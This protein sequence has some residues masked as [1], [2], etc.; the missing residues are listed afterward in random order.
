MT[1]AL[2]FSGQG[3]QK[4]GMGQDLYETQAPYRDTI[5][6]A[7][8]VLGIDLPALYFDG[9]KADQLNETQYTQPAI[10]AMSMAVYQTIKLQLDDQVKVGLGLSLGEY[11]ALAASGFLTFDEALK[12]IALRGQLMQKASDDN[13]SK[14]VAVMN[15]PLEVL[16]E[17]VKAGQTTGRVAIANVNT[18]KQVVIGGDV[19]AVD[20]ASAYLTDHDAG[21]QVTLNVSGAFHTPLMQSAQQPLHEALT[22]VNWQQGHFPIMSTTQLQPFTPAD[23][24]TTLTDQLVSTTHFSDA[25]TQVAPD[26]DTVIEVGPGKTLMSFAR[27]TVKGLNYYHIDSAETLTDTLAALAAQK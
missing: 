19:S 7:S 3:S 20:A 13:P 2:L 8:Q 21:R 22:Q 17:A 5:D 24:V 14:M 15:T 25:L 26:V 27:K 10:V 6:H 12:L 11:S 16:Q 9:T 18:P 4:T 1:I 23:I